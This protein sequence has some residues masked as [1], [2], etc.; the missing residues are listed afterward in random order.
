MT[1]YESKVTV[2]QPKA[3]IF[4]QMADL[5]NLEKHKEKFPNNADLE[6]QFAQDFIT[7]KVPVVGHATIRLVEKEAQ[8]KL[9][10]SV[11][12]LPMTANIYVKLNEIETEKTEIQ[13]V[14]EAD[15]PFFLGNILG[16]KLQNG[17]NK[18]TEMIAATLNK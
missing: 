1:N 16:D 11:E 7:A 6:I 12:N 9:K 17:L 15:I 2:N 5:R 4:E 8:E 14:L 10:F 18:T 13:L 3:K